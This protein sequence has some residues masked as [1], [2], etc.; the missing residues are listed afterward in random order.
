MWVLG[1]GTTQKGGVL[2]AGTAQKRGVLGAGTPKKGD[3]R[4]I[5]IQPKKGGIWNWFCKKR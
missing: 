1:A 5:I 3:I 4:Y 2:S